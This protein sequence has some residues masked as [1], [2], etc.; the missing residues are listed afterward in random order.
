MD[1]L[2]NL[3][4]KQRSAPIY[5]VFGIQ[6]LLEM[7]SSE[8]NTLVKPAL[9]DDP[10]E[11]FILTLAIQASPN[12]NS[13]VVAK[14]G[15][16]GQCWSMLRESDAMWRIYSPDKNGV[17]VRTTVG[18]LFDSL[19]NAPEKRGESFIGKVFY[20]KD[21]ELRSRIR[22][23]DWLSQEITNSKSQAT[24][25]LF[26]RVEFEHEAEIR[27]LYLSYSPPT[28]NLFRYSIKP[29]ELFDEIQ[30]DPRLSGEVYQAY[31]YYLE[32]KVGFHNPISQSE[33][34]KVPN[35]KL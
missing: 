30:F 25:L 6:R 2:I 23:R 5:R 12:P 34:Y 17:K 16:F 15:F 28:D 4:R 19:C 35:V 27:L 22:D 9:W 24:S 32:E 18:K 14:D 10:F 8:N 29:R 13:Y 1:Q 31:K 26:K 21:A 20:K 3:T 7:F 33:L 11:N